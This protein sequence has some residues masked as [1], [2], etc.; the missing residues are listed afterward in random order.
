MV[1]NGRQYQN[2]PIP[3]LNRQE[4][5]CLKFLVQYT[6]HLMFL[7]FVVIFKRSEI[8]LEHPV[9][10]RA[11]LDKEYRIVSYKRSA[12]NLHARGSDGALKTRCQE[13]GR[14]LLLFWST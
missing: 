5:S 4:V 13:K 12:S 9:A 14:L 6:R 8:Y 10:E 11:R 2:L 3:L 1:L 7:C